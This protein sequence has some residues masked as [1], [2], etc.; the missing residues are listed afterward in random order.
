MTDITPIAL[1]KLV[2]S[3]DN[4]RRTAAIDAGLQE[5]TA[6]IAAH[7][8]LQSLVVRK[9]RKRK[10]AVVAGGRR[11]CSSSPNRAGSRRP[12]PCRARC[13]TA[14]TLPNSA[15]PKTLIR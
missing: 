15:S 13:V 2:V 14:T 4:V 6:S 9:H 3:E 1:G 12:L 7:G 11:R 5:L 10:F 8:L